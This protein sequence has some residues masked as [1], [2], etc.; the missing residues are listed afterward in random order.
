LEINDSWEGRKI[1]LVSEH[2]DGVQR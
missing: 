2:I 1:F